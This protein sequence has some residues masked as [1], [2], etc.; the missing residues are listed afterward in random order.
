[1][2]AECIPTFTYEILLLRGALCGSIVFLAQSYEM[3]LLQMSVLQFPFHS[4]QESDCW[5]HLTQKWVFNWNHQEITSKK[6]ENIKIISLVSES[7]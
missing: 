4:P 2:T 3:V 6:S 7:R 5:G 1:M